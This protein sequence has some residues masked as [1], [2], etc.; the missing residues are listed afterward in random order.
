MIYGQGCAGV[1]ALAWPASFGVMHFTRRCNEKEKSRKET[2]VVKRSVKI[3]R[4]EIFTTETRR[5]GEKQELTA[6]L[7]G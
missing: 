6:D 4:E 5:H 3:Y 1:R 2:K 7:R